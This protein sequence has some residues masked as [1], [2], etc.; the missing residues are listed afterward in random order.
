MGLVPNAGRGDASGVP[1][2][3]PFLP[4]L[5]R[6]GLRSEFLEGAMLAI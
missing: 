4:P 6:S 2:P 1:N 5:S 3:I